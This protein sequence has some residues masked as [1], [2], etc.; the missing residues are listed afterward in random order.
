M[1]QPL[2]KA[3]GN[4]L[5]V[6]EAVEVLKGREKGRLYELCMVLA[7]NML[8]LAGKGSLQECRAFAENAVECGDALRIFKR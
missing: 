4:A 5:E 6:I 8:E 7:A 1:N 3:V 2:G